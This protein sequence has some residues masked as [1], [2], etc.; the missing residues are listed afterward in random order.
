MDKVNTEIR[1]LLNQKFTEP[2][3]EEVPCSLCGGKRHLLPVNDQFAFYVHR[4]E[5]LDRC[6]AIGWRTSFLKDYYAY[7]SELVK[8]ESSVIDSVKTSGV[9]INYKENTDKKAPEGYEAAWERCFRDRA[10]TFMRNEPPARY[11][12]RLWLYEHLEGPVLDIG[13]GNAVDYVGFRDKGYHGVDI[14]PSFIEAAVKEFGVPAEAL[15]LCDARKMPFADKQFKSAYIRDVL[16]HYPQEEMPPFI[17]EML[18]V[19]ENCYVSW[20]G[21]GVRSFAP[22]YSPEQTMMTDEEIVKWQEKERFYYTAPDRK[23]LEDRYRLTFI[24][25]TN[26]TRVDRLE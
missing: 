18:R 19:A 25:D 7:M 10:N 5:E 16:L 15:T 6:N 13:C 8:G 20:G 26:I 11:A 3:A 17:D 12:D 4:G 22:T 21:F 1:R 14:T 2:L 9:H 24:E 23:Y